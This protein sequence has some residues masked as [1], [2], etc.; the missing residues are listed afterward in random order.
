MSF[1]GL[2]LLAMTFH[3]K[4]EPLHFVWIFS[5]SPKQFMKRK[6][7]YSA[8]SSTII[9]LP[10]LIAL[11]IFFPMNIG[12]ALLVYVVGQLFLVSMILAKYSAYPNEINVP[13]AILYGLSLWFPPMLIVVCI[14]FYKRSLRNLNSILQ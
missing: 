10:A 6:V 3:A 5:D 8:I 14:I 12:T 9:G 4:P 11:G 1:A 7:T 13:Q 2:F